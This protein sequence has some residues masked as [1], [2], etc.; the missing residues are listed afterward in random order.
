[1]DTK[2][3]LSFD[4]TVVER[5]KEF[6]EENNISLS[7]L[8]EYLLRKATNSNCQLFEDMPIA[9]WVNAVAAG[10]V[11]YVTKHRSRSAYKKEF[12]SSKGKK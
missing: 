1:M 3:T 6:A 7:R 4:Q 2:V 5:A 12:F 10:E 11:E 8:T 9:D